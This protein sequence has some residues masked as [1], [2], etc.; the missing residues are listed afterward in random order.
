MKLRA[1]GWLPEAH[2]HTTVQSIS[3]QV[4]DRLGGLRV[5]DVDVDCGREPG[6]DAGI[7]RVGNTVSQS[8]IYSGLV[9]V[10]FCHSFPAGVQS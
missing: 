7:A 5:Q 3:R 4:L 8:L 6:A 9:S 10:R 1:L 2:E